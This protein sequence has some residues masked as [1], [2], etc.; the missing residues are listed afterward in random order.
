ML[1]E[2]WQQIQRLLLLCFADIE[3]VLPLQRVVRSL[4][5]ALPQ[6]EIILLTPHSHQLL[7]SLSSWVAIASL[8]QW[9][10]EPEVDLQDAQILN[11]ALITA[12]RDRKFDAA[13]IFT[14]HHVSPFGLAYLCY[15]AGIP[16]RVGQ[17]HEFGGG[18]LSECVKPPLDEVAIEQYYL[19]QLEAIG[20]PI[21]E[22][23]SA[24]ILSCVAA[25]G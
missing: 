22:E 15:L 2:Q 14:P 6:A 19:H 24:S 5:Q 25:T 11:P 16:I 20:L 21:I 13:M 3:A 1:P 18:V 17:S 8:H 7:D 9:I 23:P 4:R 10:G 12:M